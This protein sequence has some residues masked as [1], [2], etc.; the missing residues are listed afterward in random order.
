MLR[1]RLQGESEHGRTN[2]GD[3]V[4]IYKLKI[5]HNGCCERSADLG[6]FS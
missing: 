1:S 4:P 3:G 2:G 5:I 6:A